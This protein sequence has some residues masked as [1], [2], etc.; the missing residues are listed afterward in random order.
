MEHLSVIR[1]LC[2][3]LFFVSFLAG[4]AAPYVVPLKEHASYTAPGDPNKGIVFIYRESSMMGV[5]RGIY[6]KANG[7]RVGALNSGT[8][9]V[10]QADPGPVTFAA[11]DWIQGDRTRTL[12]VE[13]G[14]QYY[15]RGTLS[16]GVPDVEPRIEIVN[17][18]EGKEAIKGL[19]YSTLE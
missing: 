17:D 12:D 11:E 13:A 2:I 5:L 7:K 19:R 18:N 14:K 10:Y 9:F 16:P 8:Y 15:I 1:R 4:C 3:H 6:I